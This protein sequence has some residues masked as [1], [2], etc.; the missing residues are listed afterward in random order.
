METFLMYFLFLVGVVLIVKGG[1]WFVDSAAWIAEATG[2]PRFVIGATIVSLATTLPEII[3]STIAACQGK[4]DMAIGNAVGSV[5]ANVGLIMAISILLMPVV[6]SKKSVLVKVLL[7]FGAVG[8]LWGMSALGPEVSGSAA[9]LTV[10]G[11]IPVL[12]LFVVFI[13]E[14]LNAMKKESVKDETKMKPEKKE[15]FK[16]ILILLIGA[17]CIV[18]GSQ[19]LVNE[20]SAI[21]AGLGVPEKVVSLTAIA[22][23]TSLPELVTAITAIIKK[24][25]ALSVGN[26]IGANIIDICLILPICS[27]ISGGALPITTQNLRLDLPVCLLV[28]LICL[29]PILFTGK[30]KRWQGALALAIYA[31]YLGV[32]C[33]GSNLPM[34]GIA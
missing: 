23:G 16:N 14:N 21:A 8:V 32:V 27:F 33:F 26:I 24:Q 11:S 17:G 30:Q 2:I 22:I 18:G 6:V 12:A 34:L 10:L 1:D 20:G 28:V 25:G 15:I 13:F 4:T 5:T 9:S 31:A 7:L 3:V 19:L 29:L